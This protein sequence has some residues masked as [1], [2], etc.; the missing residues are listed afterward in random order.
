MKAAP[1]KSVD[2]TPPPSSAIEA[3]SDVALL[4]PDDVCQLI[5]K[6]QSWLFAAVK[7]GEFPAPVLREPRSTRWRAST[8]RTHLLAM[9]ERSENDPATGIATRLK[10]AKASVEAQARRAAGME[11]IAAQTSTA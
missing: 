8:V 5:R 4:T 9:I 1:S 11:A 7:S 10:A 3:L 6:S 2:R